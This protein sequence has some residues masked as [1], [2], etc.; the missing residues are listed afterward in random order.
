VA[1]NTASSSTIYWHNLLA[2]YWP[3]I[4]PMQMFSQRIA[5]ELCTRV[6]DLYMW[7]THWKN[8]FAEKKNFSWIQI[9]KVISLNYQN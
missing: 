4:A 2:Q 8:G 5:N 7:Y 3:N 1:L 6:I 9:R